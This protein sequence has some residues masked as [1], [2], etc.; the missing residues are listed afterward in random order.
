MNNEAPQPLAI[1]VPEH[2][3]FEVIQ[4]L[5]KKLTKEIIQRSQTKNIE[6]LTL[7]DYMIT[8]QQYDNLYKS[9]NL[10]DANLFLQKLK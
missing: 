6:E 1:P 5:D 7:A 10:Q 8:P 2:S 4:G 9:I 3:P